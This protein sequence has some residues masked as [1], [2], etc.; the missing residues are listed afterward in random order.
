MRPM[1]LF[2]RLVNRI[3]LPKLNKYIPFFFFWLAYTLSSCLTLP[4]KVVAGALAMLPFSPAHIHRQQLHNLGLHNPE[5]SI[6][7]NY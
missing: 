3:P 4:L 5:S 2:K 7:I 1:C 6:Y